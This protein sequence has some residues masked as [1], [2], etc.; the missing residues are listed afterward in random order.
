VRIL[1]PARVRIGNNTAINIHTSLDGN[2]GLSI[3]NDVMIGPYCQILTDSHKF[4]SRKIPMKEQG[5]KTAPV[6]IE[7]YAWL[8]A[9]VI[10]LPGVTIGSG[11]IIGAGAVV[12][13][14]VES[15]H[16]VAGVPAKTIR[17]R[18]E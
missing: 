13:C 3:G 10:V 7:E 9:N 6:I 1:C 18:P 8:G 16:I 4:E 5:I 17:V 15:F 14:N 2:G 12:S 11:A